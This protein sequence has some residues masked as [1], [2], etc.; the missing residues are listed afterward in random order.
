M[1]AKFRV[2]ELEPNL[3]ETNSHEISDPSNFRDGGFRFTT[4]FKSVV[5]TLQCHLI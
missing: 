2:F 3:H 1:G 4:D 5:S